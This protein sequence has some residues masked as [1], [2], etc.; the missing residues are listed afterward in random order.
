MTAEN[1]SR[2]AVRQRGA[3]PPPVIDCAL[4]GTRRPCPAPQGERD[5]CI[6]CPHLVGEA[7]P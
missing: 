7:R 1:T 6:R 2:K 5:S 4:A 3:K